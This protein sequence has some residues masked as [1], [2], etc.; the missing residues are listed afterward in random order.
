MYI[1]DA[2]CIKLDKKVLN[3]MDRCIKENNYSTKTEFIREAIRD[4]MTELEKETAIA[5]LKKLLGAS[6][7]KTSE[8]EYEKGREQVAREY[9][10]KFGLELD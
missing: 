4:K 6:K 7:K 8:E 9:A 1:M 3:K 10:K 2:V 5:Q